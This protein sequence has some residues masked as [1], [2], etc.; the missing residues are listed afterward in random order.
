MKWKK[1]LYRPLES[2][3]AIDENGIIYIGSALDNNYLFAIYSNNGTEKWS[4]YTGNLVT[5]SPAI[6][7]DGTIYFGDWNGIF[8][9]INPNG[10]EKWK[11]QTGDAI[12]SSPA[13]G[14]DGIV[15]CGSHDGSLYAYYPQ[16]GTV[17][18]KFPA[19][20][21]IRV[22]PCIGDDGTI[23]CVS[24]NNFLFA[25][26]PN[27]TM[28]W[29]T[30]VD[31]GTSP[32]IGPDG[33][34]YA[35]WDT[36]YAINSVD[37]SVKWSLPVSGAIEGSTPCTSHEGVIYFG[38]T[39]GDVYA[40]NPNGTIRWRKT[41]VESQSPAAIGEDGTIYIGMY[42]IFNGRFIGY[43]C[44]YG[45]GPQKKMTITEPKPG[46]LYVFGKEK[47]ETQSGITF[48][49]GKV[50]I[51]AEPTIPLEIDHVDFYLKSIRSGSEDWIFGFSDNK[52]PYEWVL[53]QRITNPV[54]RIP[55]LCYITIA[56]TAYYKGGCRWGDT[57]NKMLYFHLL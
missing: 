33:T 36:L 13:I 25:I 32:T 39:N 53:N 46:K 11:Y 5:S 14:A 18:W 21:W 57:I 45:P 49:I 30:D 40:V 34:I 44:A 12:L 4:Y 56:V 8:H 22:N 9:A 55:P 16:N 19:G 17:K 47:G 24:L 50:T 20:Y 43:L 28:K 35:G 48:A 54:I 26:N 38:T 27:G 6:G 7:A 37:G 15:Y 1:D 2:T 41:F 31:A 3:P 52:S 23:Y 10:T 51:V 29:K 42:T